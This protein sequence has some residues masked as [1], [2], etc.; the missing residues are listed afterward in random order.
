MVLIAM[1][2]LIKLLQHGKFNIKRKDEI[3][4][5]FRI[6]RDE[7]FRRYYENTDF[8]TNPNIRKNTR[9]LIVAKKYTSSISAYLHQ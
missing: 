3:K 6:I 8:S 1:Q 7:P 5:I 4:N 2:T 9:N